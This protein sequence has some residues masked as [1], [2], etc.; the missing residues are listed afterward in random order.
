M[1]LLIWS[2][3]VL[4]KQIKIA[5]KL[6]ISYNRWEVQC[7]GVKHNKLICNTDINWTTCFGL[8][9][10]HHQ[11]QQALWRHIYYMEFN[12]LT[13]NGHFSSRTAPLTYRCC[14]FLFIQQIY[15]LHI[16]NMLHTL[17][18]FP[19]QNVVYFLMLPFL[20]P[21]LFTFYIQNVLKFKRKFRRQRVKLVDVEIS[22]S[23]FFSI[24]RNMRR[25][26]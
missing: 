8:L 24:L 22:S 1:M 23:I 7:K 21:V 5:W 10:G 2:T 12:H 11:V 26:L 3:D 19:L 9:R 20:V 15:V 13:P 14:I 25:K 17:R 4:V 16:L 18:F 6:S